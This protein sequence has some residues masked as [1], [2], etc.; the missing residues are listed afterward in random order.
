MFVCVCVCTM[1]K[2][3]KRAETTSDYENQSRPREKE[4]KR[5]KDRKREWKQK[6]DK[7][8]ERERGCKWVYKTPNWQRNVPG[9]PQ[10]SSWLDHD[11]QLVRAG[12]GTGCLGEWRRVGFE[13]TPH[14]P[15][16]PWP[17]SLRDRSNR[18]WENTTQS[19][20]RTH[21]LSCFY[22]WELEPLTAALPL[23][24]AALKCVSNVTWHTRCVREM[25]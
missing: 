24:A 5:E 3:L 6:R 21:H 13:W 22:D 15:D 12:S 7:E 23:L 17:R 11:P 8:S 19:Y 4:R 1:A 2:I 16:A 14:S 10:S 20:L 18:K 25:R 9:R